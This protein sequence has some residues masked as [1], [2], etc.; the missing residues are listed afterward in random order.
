M[1]SH[2]ASLVG[3]QL[4]MF[5]FSHIQQ[6]DCSAAWPILCAAVLLHRPF[7]ANAENNRQTDCA[8]NPLHPTSTGKLQ[9]CQPL[10]L[11]SVINSSY[12]ALSRS[13]ASPHLSSK[14]TVNPMMTIFF[15]AADHKTMSCL[16]FVGTI[17]GNLSFLSR[18]TSS[19]QS[20]LGIVQY[21]YPYCFPSLTNC[22]YTGFFF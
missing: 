4:L 14:G 2:C 19:F 10:S 3:F 1:I 15:I 13:F 9:V 18:S 17:S 5:L 16:K 6:D 21:V 8:G 20:T 12:L 11:H 7:T 22:I